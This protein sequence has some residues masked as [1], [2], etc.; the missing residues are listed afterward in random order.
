MTKLL[1]F[2]VSL[3][4]ICSSISRAYLASRC[5]TTRLLASQTT[6]PR[7]GDAL[8]RYF[9]LETLNNSC[10]IAE[11]CTQVKLMEIAQYEP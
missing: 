3:T 6:N 5:A 2:H 10:V 9:D 7:S 1:D 11:L 4:R 8:P